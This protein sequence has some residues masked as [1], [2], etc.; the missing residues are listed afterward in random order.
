LFVVNKGSGNLTA[1][2]TV[3]NTTTSI[4]MGTGA[5]SAPVYSIFD[6]RR[7]RLY[8]ANFGDNSVTV[9]DLSQ[10]TPQVLKQVVSLGP[11]AVGPTTIAPLAD[12]TR[13][14]VANTTSNNVSVIDASS[15]TLSTTNAANP[16]SLGTPA[17]N[18]Q[19]LWIESEPTSTKILVT[20]PAPAPGTA[21]ANNPNA[22][23]GVTII[24]TDTNTISNFVQGPKGDP[25]CQIN[26]VAVP[27]TTCSFQL[28]LQILTYA[29]N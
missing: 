23:A 16:I 9:L 22:A 11:G 1:I 17:S 20:T 29:H 19:P 12:G 25:N 24:R 14:Y 18:T 8:V 28:P 5:T 2:H 7:N 13:Y 26:P 6:S 3:D 21:P 15:N 27:P 10:S 4:A